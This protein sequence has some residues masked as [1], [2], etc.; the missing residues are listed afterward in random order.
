MRKDPYYILVINLGLKSPMAKES[1]AMSSV[2]AQ[3][4][5]ISSVAGR[6]RVEL[7]S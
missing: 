6:R 1:T 3:K 7:T 5:K 2:A 4:L